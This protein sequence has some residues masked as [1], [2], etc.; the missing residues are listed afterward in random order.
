[1]AEPPQGGQRP[2]PPAGATGYTGFVMG[3]HRERRPDSPGSGIATSQVQTSVARGDSV[4]PSTGRGLFALIAAIAT[5][6]VVVGVLVDLP[7]L[8]I[9]GAIAVIVAAFALLTR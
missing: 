8:V 7:V 9:A 4:P 3:E 5:A 2:K 6:A 1:M